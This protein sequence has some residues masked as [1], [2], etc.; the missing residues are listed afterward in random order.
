M[1]IYIFGKASTTDLT[2]VL[3]A[4]FGRAPCTVHIASLTQRHTHL[5]PMGEGAGMAQMGGQVELWPGKKRS[6]TAAAAMEALASS[7]DEEARENAGSDAIIGAHVRNFLATNCDKERKDIIDKIG[8][9][10]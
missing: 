10:K 9:L 2:Y 1:Y 6:P 8:S 4:A 3:T 7:S 5:R